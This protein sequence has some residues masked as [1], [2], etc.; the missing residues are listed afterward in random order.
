MI[1]AYL[2]QFGRDFDAENWINY[3]NEP[4]EL[5]SKGLSIFIII[6]YID[7]GRRFEVVKEF[8]GWCIIGCTK[9]ISMTLGN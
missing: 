2:G 5:V 3:V 1:W 4:M 8:L 6:L 7:C 9:E